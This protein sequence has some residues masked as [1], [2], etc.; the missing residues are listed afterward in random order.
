MA[1]EVIRIPTLEEADRLS[2]E[3]DSQ[4]GFGRSTAGD[5]VR[6]LLRQAMADGMSKIAVGVDPTSG[7]PYM[8]YGRQKSN[9]R[10]E[11]WDMVAPPVEF[12]PFL[13]QYLLSETE[14][15]PVMPPRGK[16]LAVD[17]ARRFELHVEL[18][19]PNAFEITWVQ[20]AE[21]IHHGAT[22]FTE[23]KADS[24]PPRHRDTEAQEKWMKDDR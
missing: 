11:A 5:L 2:R 7:K 6:F 12:F 23:K 21:G 4:A 14:L 3:L 8:K 13:L 22:E 19:V 1:Q 10:F 18:T 24:E 9:G 20:A 17:G 15:E 16:A